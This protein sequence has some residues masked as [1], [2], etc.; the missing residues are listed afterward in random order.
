MGI[1][2]EGVATPRRR[3]LRHADRGAAP[4]EGL[5]A[6]LQGAVLEIGFGTRRNV[7]H[8]PAAVTQVAA[9]EPADLAWKAGWRPGGGGNRPRSHDRDSTSQLPSSRS[10]GS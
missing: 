9:I 10:G 5:R 8:D 6:D 1:S 7:P 4:V 2:R 3:D